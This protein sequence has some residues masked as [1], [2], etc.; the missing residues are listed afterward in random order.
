MTL[1]V[2]PH[3]TLGAEGF[4]L[5]VGDDVFLSADKS[6]SQ[7][8]HKVIH[9]V[10]NVVIN[11][12]DETLYG[13]SAKVNL[14]DQ[15][16]EISGNV[17]YIS[18]ELTIYGSHLNY[19]FSSGRVELDNARII[20]RGFTI[21]GD[22]IVRDEKGE[23]LATEA[24]YTTCRDCPESWTLMGREVR[25]IKDKYVHIKHALVKIKGI[26][27]LY[28]PYISIP[29]KKKR[30][31]GL[32]FPRFEIRTQQGVTFQQPWFWAMSDQND[33]TLTPSVYG[34]RGLGGEV[35]YRHIFGEKKWIDFGGMGVYD[36]IYIPHQNT[37]DVSGHHYG[38]YFAKYEQHFQLEN[39]LFHHM[40]YSF[41][42]DLDMIKDYNEYVRD[43]TVGSEFGGDGFFGHRTP[44]TFI[45]AESY[46]GR[47]L[48]INDEK[49]FDNSY[50][51]ILPRFALDITPFNLL[52]TKVF[53]FRKISLGL[54]STFTAFKQNHSN[55]S[56][57]IARNANRVTANPYLDWQIAFLG[58][59]ELKAVAELDYQHYRFRDERL[60][61]FSKRGTLFRTE[62]VVELEKVLGLAYEENVPIERVDVEEIRKQQDKK[63]KNKNTSKSLIGNLPA[64]ETSLTKGEL[65]NLRNSYRH[66]QIIKTI[67]HFTSQQKFKGNQDFLDQ[68]RSQEHLFDYR[69]VVRAE[70]GLIGNNES[71]KALSTRNTVELQ[72]NNKLI[73]KT[74]SNS[75]VF[76]DDRFLIDNFK[77]SRIAFFNVSQGY[78]LNTNSIHWR[79][80]LERLHIE[81]GVTMGNWNFSVDEYYIYQDGKHIFSSSLGR[82]FAYGEAEI[83]YEY[84]GYSNPRRRLINFSG[85]LIPVDIFKFEVQYEHDLE[86]KNLMNSNYSVTYMPK[87]NCWRFEISYRDD[88]L[89]RRVGFNVF[90]NFSKE[91]NFS[92]FKNSKG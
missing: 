86:R 45:T 44:F 30:E 1:L 47:N 34:R 11:F 50:V 76:K 72:W 10:G 14:I 89:D 24:Q 73:R 32:L 18:K 64:Y 31:T 77:Y 27:I 71:R 65:V 25:L 38:R 46:F 92:S 49:E 90:F 12:L 85:S 70:E 5:K 74:V 68:I 13:E 61:S 55:E 36:R 48:L 79:D 84:N 22:R 81:S 23:Y 87:S 60:Q 8:N 54:E 52:Q 17:R 7:G 51:Q 63:E 4:Q 43:R 29:I 42:R 6:F 69:D 41:A 53:G 62:A 88:S 75:D 66:T 26:T 28:L 80:D 56:G 67:H 39:S 33:L 16:I 3:P 78:R 57:L 59:L 15:V 40:Q 2:L 21:L 35:E 20:S 9:A 91:G 83:G 37:S 82:K 58:P 19:N